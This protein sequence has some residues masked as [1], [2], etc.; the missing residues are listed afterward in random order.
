[1]EGDLSCHK[2]H[3]ITQHRSCLPRA[4]G[5]GVSLLPTATENTRPARRGALHEN[6]SSVP[7]ASL[8]RSLKGLYAKEFPAIAFCLTLGTS[9][10]Q[11]ICKKRFA[12]YLLKNRE[13]TNKLQ[14]GGGLFPALILQPLI[15]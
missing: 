1:M 13:A 11:Q 15:V 10:Q 3:S 14:W 2:A 7:S 5:K 4:P 8:H 9:W 12:F 6:H